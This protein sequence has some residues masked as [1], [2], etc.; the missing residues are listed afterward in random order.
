MSECNACNGYGHLCED[1]DE[2]I[3][4]DVWC[5]PCGDELCESCHLDHISRHAAE[6]A[7]EPDELQGKLRTSRR[8]RQ[9]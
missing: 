6:R 1:C 2:P 7:A 9:R 5:V 4:G 8:E 3:P